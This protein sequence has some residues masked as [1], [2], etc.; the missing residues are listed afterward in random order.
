[1]AEKT[2]YCT[3]ADVQR[4]VKRIEFAA[5]TKVT[6]SDVDTYIQAASNIV[7]GELHKL[8]VT[9]PVPSTAAVSMEVLK[10]LVSFEAASWAEQAANYGSSKN[11][12]THGEWLHTQYSNLL[13]QIQQNPSLLSD[14]VT[15]SVAHMKS[16]TEDMNVGEPKEG[17]EIFT[18]KSIDDFRDSFKILSPSEKA[19]EPESIT[20][21]VDRTRI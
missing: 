12:S 1:M 6:P 11:A 19:S 7:D 21:E 2:V 20:G 17:D 16:D 13:E 10:L 5:N 4:W 9:L 15:G 14:I 18:E 8:G 3:M